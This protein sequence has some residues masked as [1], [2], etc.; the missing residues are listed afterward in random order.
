[1]LHVAEKLEAEGARLSYPHSRSVQGEDGK[2]LWE[3]RPRSGR[4][5]WRPIYRQVAP[6]AFLILAIGPEAEID[7]AGFDA[8]VVRARRRMDE[9]DPG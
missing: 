4:S 6:G 1:M 8:A 9:V 7:R 2:G 5:R 3:L